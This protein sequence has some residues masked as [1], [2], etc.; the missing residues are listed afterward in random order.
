MVDALLEAD[1]YLST[2]QSIS[3]SELSNAVRKGADQAKD[4]LA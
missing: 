2:N 3:L 4:L 1:H